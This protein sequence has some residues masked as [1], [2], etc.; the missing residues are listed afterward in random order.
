MS[1]NERAGDIDPLYRVNKFAVPD[2]ARQE[3][4]DL[5]A[6]TFAV[7]R[8]QEG[9]VRDWVLEQNSGPGVFNFV[10]M[11]EFAS[12]E[13]APR[14]AA[15]LNELDRNLGLDREAMMTRLG[16]RTDFGGYKRLETASKD[17]R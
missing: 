11:I 13:V 1:G 7:V 10:T 17:V 5:V 6:R 2:A 16:I 3:F 12:D 4:L 9:Y 15:A 14:V 8:R